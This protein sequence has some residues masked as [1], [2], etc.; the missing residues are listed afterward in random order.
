MR[1]NLEGT[2]SSVWEGFLS[3]TIDAPSL[4]HTDLF[5]RNYPT[6]LGFLNILSLELAQEYASKREIPCLLCCYF[7]TRDTVWGFTLNKERVDEAF[8]S[9][10]DKDSPEVQFILQRFRLAY[11]SSR[12][13]QA[14]YAYDFARFHSPGGH[15]V[16]YR[17]GR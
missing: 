9:L 5:G 17:G 7:P 12:H 11:E 10:P 6:P 2:R 13:R 1:L 3:E 15:Y 16:G 14:I 8:R 4:D